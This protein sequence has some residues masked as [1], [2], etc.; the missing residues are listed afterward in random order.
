MGRCMRPTWLKYY[1]SLV[2]TLP[3]AVLSVDISYS[4]DIAKHV[5]DVI[6]PVGL[7]A[8]VYWRLYIQIRGVCNQ[9][10]Y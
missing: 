2:K 6:E 10:V 4:I 8:W 1:Q 3:T 5:S 9:Y 7:Y